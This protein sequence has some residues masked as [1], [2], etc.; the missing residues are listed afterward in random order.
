MC[1][2]PPS[3]FRGRPRWR[4]WERRDLGGPSRPAGLRRTALCPARGI[5]PLRTS[6][7][8]RR[9]NRRSG[10]HAALRL[11]HDRA[12]GG[13]LRSRVQ[14]RG[15]RP[16][17]ARPQLVH[18]GA[19]HG[20]RRQPGRA[21]RQ[22]DQDAAGVCG[23]RQ[24]DGAGRR[25]AGAGRRRARHAHDRRHPDRGGDHAADACDHPGTLR[26]S[27]GRYGSD[28]RAGA[29]AP[30]PGARR[31]SARAPRHVPGTQDRLRPESR[32]VQLLR[33]QEHHHRRR[34]DAHG[35]RGLPG[36]RAHSEPAR[37]ESRRRHALRGGRALG[38]RELAADDQLAPQPAPQRSG[39]RLRDRGGTRRRTDVSAMTRGKRG[40]DLVTAGTGLLLLAPLLALLALL[41]KLADG[42]PVFFRQ[43]RVGF[44]GRRFRIWK[45][46]T[47]AP[48]A[49][50]KGLPLTVGRDAGVTRVGRWLRQG[51]PDG[52][53]QL[54]NVLAG[55]MTLVGPR[56]E[57]PRYVAAYSARERR[58][59]EL[60]P[61]V[62]DEASIRY[63]DESAVLATAPDAERLYVSEIV[64]AKIRLNLAYAAHAT[65]WTDVAVILATLRRLVLPPTRSTTR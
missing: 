11:D 25:P 22:S 64:P 17:G 49:E 30:P 32:G 61:G 40:F 58:V 28:P 29:R 45:F 39:R 13:V 4:R 16:R 23:D 5:P 50:A 43:E 47:M 63:A 41:V 20:S 55:D 2:P 54:V 12:Q 9:R 3:P 59:L 8:R 14:G 37:P 33:D 27:S 57:V 51:E 46:R 52:L 15:L 18:R 26:R 10:R 48:D 35:G 44:Q 62:T 42:G 38:L 31:R 65:M 1:T 19:P 24:R 34:W 21:R 7:D 60:V 53:P 6:T 36:A 56:P